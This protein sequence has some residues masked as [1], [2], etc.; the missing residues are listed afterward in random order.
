MLCAGI[1]NGI[2]HNYYPQLDLELAFRSTNSD[3]QLFF[4]EDGTNKVILNVNELCKIVTKTFDAILSDE[5]EDFYSKMEIQLNI[6]N[7]EYETSIGDLLKEL[8]DS[9]KRC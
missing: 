1:R 5:S 3:K 6:L 9:L 8:K 7:A 2:A 4:L